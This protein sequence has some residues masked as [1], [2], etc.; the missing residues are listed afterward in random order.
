MTAAKCVFIPFVVAGA[1]AVT[2]LTALA[3]PE[4]LELGEAVSLIEAAGGTEE[5]PDANA[6]VIFDRMLVE[7]D[8]T[9][10]FEQYNHSLTRILTEEGA[11]DFADHSTVYHQ[12][13]GTNDI[14][15]ARI[16]KADGT[17]VVIGDDLITDGTPPTLSAMNIYETDFRE[18]T[19]VFPGLEPG[20]AIELLTLD[21]YEP[22]LEDAFAQ[23]FYLQ[24]SEPILE[25]TITIQGPPDMPLK[26]AVIGDV[27]VEFEERPV[28]EGEDSGDWTYYRWTARDVP[29]IERE[30]G[31]APMP[32]IATRLTVSTIHEW[33][34][35]SNKLWEMYD[36]KCIADEPVKDLV[37]ELTDGLE[38]KEEKIRAIH[39]WI[40]ENVRYLGIGMDF[41]AFLEPHLPSYTLEKEYGICRD[42]ALLMVA[43]LEEIGVPAWVTVI[44]VSKKTDPEVPNTSFEHGIVAVEGDDGEYLFIDPTQETSREVYATYPGDRWVMVLREGG[45]DLRKAPHYPPER[46]SGEIIETAEIHEDGS[47][48]GT[49]VI[50]GNGMYE[51]I[52]RQIARATSPEQMKMIWEESVQSLY[53][54]AEMTDF[55]S[56]DPED[57]AQPMTITV[58]YRVDDYLLEADPYVLFRVP[59]ATGAFDF[60]SEILVGRL[61]SLPERKHPVHL[62]I[63][64]G[65]VE[66]A[67]IKVPAGL[68]VK[69]MPDPVSFEE[70]IVSLDMD[71]AF[72]SPEDGSNGSISYTKTFGIDAF[73]ITPEEY[74]NLREAA[75]MADRSVRGEVILMREEG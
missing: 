8:E 24:Y 30:L 52:L 55:Q 74:R 46:N 16:I 13:Y 56:S 2:A 3:A 68:A 58:S 39:Y 66:S 19:L 5:H 57:L 7:F 29:K 21:D 17:E 4:P 48:S 59:S 32:Q 62:G 14:L 31:M 67:E 10:A 72:R 34:E 41:G 28:V 61:T 25:S 49:A 44:N 53:P 75:R 42:K 37:A 12:R 15:L 47:I 11:D 1:L 64:L 70:G 18:K 45:E 36:E 69:S 20:D 51:E 6:V 9:G 71:Y 73:Q 50:T 23:T 43:M 60:M 22:L 65:L 26:H 54:G 38:T 40:L 63:T 27:E 35:L 33:A